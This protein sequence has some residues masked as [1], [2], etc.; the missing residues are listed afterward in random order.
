MKKQT[1]DR[2]MLSYQ[3][4]QGASLAMGVNLHED[5]ALPWKPDPQ[6]SDTG[7]KMKLEDYNGQTYCNVIQGCGDLMRENVFNHW[8]LRSLAFYGFP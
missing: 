8:H 3:T 1:N 4:Q 6:Y 5:A 7:E 2:N